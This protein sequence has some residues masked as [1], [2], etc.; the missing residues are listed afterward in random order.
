M[1][2]TVNATSDSVPLHCTFCSVQTAFSTCVSDTVELT[3]TRST[4]PLEVTDTCLAT[5]A[6]PVWPQAAEAENKARRRKLRIALV[7][8][9]TMAILL[10]L[11]NESGC[12]FASAGHC[13]PL[14]I[15]RL[16]LRW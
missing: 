9:G 12:S 14:G 11:A 16:K 8:V 1:P 3:S 6:P 13:L 10:L 4:D 7:D 15:P 5:S 2:G